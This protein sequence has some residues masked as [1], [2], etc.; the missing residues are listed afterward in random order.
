M[1]TFVKNMHIFLGGWSEQRGAGQERLKAI[2]IPRSL[3]IEVSE[4]SL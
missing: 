1:S 3:S 2:R 4:C